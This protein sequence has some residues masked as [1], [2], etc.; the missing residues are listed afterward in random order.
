MQT[1]HREHKGLLQL[2][3]C[4][5]I[6]QMERGYRCFNFSFELISYAAR[7]VLL[8]VNYTEMCDYYTLDS[9]RKIRLVESIQ[10]IHNSL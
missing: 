6:G 7:I 5:I 3:V 1:V 2:Q 8:F 9:L 10:S 4:M